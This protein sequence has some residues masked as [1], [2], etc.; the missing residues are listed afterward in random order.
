M[1][2]NN[3]YGYVCGLQNDNG[4][5]KI[6]IEVTNN[7]LNIYHKKFQEVLTVNYSDIVGIELHEDIDIQQSNAKSLFYGVTLGALGGLGTGLLG[8]LLGGVKAKDIYYMEIQI[9]EGENV[10]SLFITDKKD[11]LIK[12]AKK[13]SEWYRSM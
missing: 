10:Y 3:E 8:F 6:K 4:I 11:R 1:F 7:G 9:K 2:D 12:L 13:I 5:K